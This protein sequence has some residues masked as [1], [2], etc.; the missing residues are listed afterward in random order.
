MRF[1]DTKETKKG[2]LIKGKS[3][4]IHKHNFPPGFSSSKWY[5]AS[6]KN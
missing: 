6:A 1:P 2:I 5:K 3:N 4:L